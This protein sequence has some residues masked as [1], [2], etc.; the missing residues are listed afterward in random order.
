MVDSLESRENGNSSLESR[1]DRR[2]AS[3]DVKFNHSDLIKSFLEPLK[4][5]DLNTYSHC[6]RVGLLSA[7]IAAFMHL[8]ERPLLYAGLLHDL[9]K[10]DV[11]DELLKKTEE[12]TE[13]DAQAM[14]SHV[15]NGYDAIKDDFAFTA[16]IIVRHHQFQDNKYPEELPSHNNPYSLQSQ[17]LIMEYARIL[18]LADHYDALHRENSRFGKKRFLSGAEIKQEMLRSNPDRGSVI[19]D[20]YK[21]GI[22][23]DQ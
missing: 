11:S 3:L 1:V 10:L 2:F 22:F 23:V 12:W 15:L 8:N 17:E 18:A 6:L 5:K 20:L 7:D 19:E 9:G 4:L 16:D 14:E 13:E 21:V